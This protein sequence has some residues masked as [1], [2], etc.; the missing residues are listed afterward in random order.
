M[1]GLWPHKP[2]TFRAL[3]RTFGPMWVR[4]D[5]CRRYARL[6]IAGLLEVDSRT[7]TFSCSRCGSEAYWCCLEPVRE[8]GMSD[9]RLDERDRP[10]RNPEAVRR[11][12]GGSRQSRSPPG[13]KHKIE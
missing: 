7:K 5:V 1:V 10:A 4:C 12:T 9:Y 8:T 13:A 3:A 6:R 2:Y 11:L